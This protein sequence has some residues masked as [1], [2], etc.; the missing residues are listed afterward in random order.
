MPEG[1]ADGGG[2]SRQNLASA[3]KAGFGIQY[4]GDSFTARDLAAAPHGLLIVEA[5]RI[6]TYEAGVEG[7]ILFDCRDIAAVRDS[8]KRVLGYVNVT[9]IEVYRDYWRDHARRTSSDA[10]FSAEW[11][12]PKT[13]SD[14]RLARYWT[15]DWEAVLVARVDRLMVQGFDGVFL[16]DVLHYFSFV[17]GEGL[18]W[19]EAGL[20]PRRTSYATE[21]IE[22]VL[23]LASCIRR[24]RPDAIV[25]VNNGVFLP[26][27]AM[28]EVGETAEALVERYLDAIDGILVESAF[29]AGRNAVVHQALAERFAARGISVLT[30]DFADQDGAGL[31]EAFRYYVR[32]RAAEL[33]FAPYVVDDPMFDRL[34]P[35][36]SG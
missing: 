20:G 36:L 35:P 26:G 4:W 17:S 10:L 13:A 21:M 15:P 8:G 11:V 22:L 31:R 34:Y 27:D 3:L 32:D 19:S 12:G 24:Q 33:G 1:A 16:D 6:G 23:T 7:E 18:D 2:S 29:G 5:T 25:V 14:E 28:A 30:V 9:E